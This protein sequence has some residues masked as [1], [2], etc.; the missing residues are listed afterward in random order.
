MPS[1]LM[2]LLPSLALAS[3]GWQIKLPDHDIGV[4]P[5]FAYIYAQAHASSW[6]LDISHS[7]DLFTSSLN[8]K[9][10]SVDD[11]SY[12]GAQAEFTFWMMFNM[13]GGAGYLFNGEKSGPVGH[14]FAG[15]PFG[16]NAFSG[17]F[18]SLYV[19]PYTRIN[20]FYSEGDAH[21]WPEI[22]LLVKVTTYVI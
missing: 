10:I 16:D 6:N 17:P 3:G 22:G 12:W 13:G 8:L 11:E 21:L 15:F 2:T 1:L 14:I 7:H 5:S 9:Q 18:R 20:V 19:E 4:G